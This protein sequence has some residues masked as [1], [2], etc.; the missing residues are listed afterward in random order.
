M[1]HVRFTA[2]LRFRI[3]A[4][5]VV[6]A[7]GFGVLSAL[8]HLTLIDPADRAAG[9]R[10]TFLTSGTLVAL[11]VFL[12]LAL[13][14]TIT[15]RIKG[16]EL[17]IDR[18]ASGER[19][20]RIGV[21]GDDEIS[22][23][24]RRFNE[25]AEGLRVSMEER[26][27]AEEK[28]KASLA[29]KEGLLKEVHHRVKNNLQVVSSMIHLQRHRVD[30]EGTRRALLDVEVRAM[31]LIHELL[32]Q[33]DDYARVRFSDYARRLVSFLIDAL[34]DGK[35]R[36][37]I[38]TRVE[39]LCLPLDQAIPCGLI[40]SEL[41]TNA[42]KHAFPGQVEGRIVVALEEPSPGRL[43]LQV[44]DDGVGMSSACDRPASL[45][46]VLVRS[47][48]SQLGGEARFAEGKG[49]SVAVEFPG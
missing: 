45:G 39:N 15:R 4:A 5:I 12:S 46:L 1:S 43:R 22:R 47:L 42:M 18:F 36:V 27:A 48:A 10:A 38:E 17:V 16:L 44:S 8:I 30:H 14:M 6:A 20:A 29:E 21:R 9:M 32:Y 49:V 31:A 23:L 25:L 34:D 26:A 37:L 3:P 24:K 35:G 19:G 2:S 28:A 33:T 7:L 41:V 11:A 13:D 40:I